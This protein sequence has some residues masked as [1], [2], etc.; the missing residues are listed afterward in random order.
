MA[1]YG[2]EAA[3][4]LLKGAV[5]GAAAGVCT[6]PVC[7]SAAALAE[8]SGVAEA[9]FGAFAAGIYMFVP[10]LVLGLAVGVLA[11]LLATG[12]WTL[13]RVRHAEVAGLNSGS[14]IAAL[15]L[16]ASQLATTMVLLPDVPSVTITISVVTATLAFFLERR[17]G[18][19]FVNGLQRRST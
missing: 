17:L 9:T 7:V 2:S 10:G 12:I 5:Y 19:R 4:V 18:A 8:R 3:R 14:A 15:V 6:S 13:G 11:T 1:R 16:A